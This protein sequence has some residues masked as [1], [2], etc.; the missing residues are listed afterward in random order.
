MRGAVALVGLAALVA[1][2]TGCGGS[3]GPKEPVYA[4]MTLSAAKDAALVESGSETTDGSNE[5]YGHH[6]K[7]LSMTKGKDLVGN[8]AWQATFADQTQNG[9]KL[10]IWMAQ[11]QYSGTLMLVP[12]PK[13]RS[14]P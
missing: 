4:G 12:C 1:T 6:L 14:S 11:G 7:L 13:R 2:S 3:N 10:C 8:P 9:E 5:I